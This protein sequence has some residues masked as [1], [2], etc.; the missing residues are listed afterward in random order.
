MRHVIGEYGCGSPQ[1]PPRGS[2]AAPTLPVRHPFEDPPC[3]PPQRQTNRRSARTRP[4]RRRATDEVPSAHHNSA[5]QKSG[6]R[7]PICHVTAD[8]TRAAGRLGAPSRARTGRAPPLSDRRTTPAAHRRARH[9]V[10]PA[11]HPLD[12]RKKRNRPCP[13]TVDIRLPSHRLRRHPAG[14][15]SPDNGKH[16]A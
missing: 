15:T 14:L 4:S 13:M 2:A 12:V 10:S 1:H 11:R 5:T 9:M 3:Y 8:R 16:R 6:R 7:A